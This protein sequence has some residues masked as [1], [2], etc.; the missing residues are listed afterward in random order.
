M[1]TRECIHCVKFFECDGK[2]KD[3]PCLHYEERKKVTE[4]V[5]NKMDKAVY[6]HI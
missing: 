2:E 5:G 3:E 4:D 1:K 6:R